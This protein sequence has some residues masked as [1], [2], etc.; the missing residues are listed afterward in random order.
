M[1]RLI[2]PTGGTWQE[3]L[4]LNAGWHKRSASTTR[5]NVSAYTVISDV[6]CW[7]MR[8]LI[9]PTG[10]CKLGWW[11]I[12]ET[13]DCCNSLPAVLLYAINIGHFHP[14]QRKYRYT[15]LLH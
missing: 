14:S 3:N 13:A 15:C 2:H 4:A 1:R 6:C 10:S 12:P 5:A 8:K 7:W 11:L 9:H